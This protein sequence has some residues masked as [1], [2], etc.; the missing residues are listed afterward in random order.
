[1]DSL[2]GESF[3]SSAKSNTLQSIWKYKL[4]LPHPIRN[5]NIISLGEGSGNL[6]YLKNISIQTGL[7]IY[8][9]YYGFNPTGTHKD[10]GMSVAVSMAKELGVTSAITFSTGNAGTSLSAYCSAAGIKTTIITRDTISKEKL[11]NILALGATV[12]VIND[13]DDPWS[14]LNDLSKFMQVYYF[15][16]FI[17]PFRAEGH[18]TLA[19]DIFTEIGNTPIAIYEP[20]GTGGGI[21]GSWKGFR[22]LRDM[23]LTDEI[24][25]INAV[26]PEAVKHAVVAYE[27]GK[28][29][30]TAYGDGNMTKIQSLADSVPLFGD[31][32]PLKAIY[33]SHGKAI[34]VTDE[35]TKTALLILGKDGLFVEPAAACSLAG[36]LKD[37]NEGTY[38]KGDAIVLSLTGTGLK[39]PDFSLDAVSK[40]IITMKSPDV[41]SLKNYIKSG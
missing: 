36:L 37:I 41:T 27:N 33:D 12:I 14:L 38:D 1:M 6:I 32:R 5:E 10:I 4:L 18:K 15:T 20:L 25:R 40:N 11:S 3:F 7:K 21:W 19:Y 9:R 35:E 23:D 17:N 2:D 16:N 24:P 8:A 30:A 34:A 39:Q 31:E 22:E 28:K 29:T 26:Q 13:L